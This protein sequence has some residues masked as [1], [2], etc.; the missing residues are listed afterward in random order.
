MTLL[1]ISAAAEEFPGRLALVQG[2]ARYTFAELATEVAELSPQLPAPR[3]GPFPLIASNE[4]ETVVKLLALIERRVPFLPLHPRLCDDERERLV[5]RALA[6]PFAAA[7]ADAPMALL[8]TS[9]TSAEPKGVLLPRSAFEIAARNSLA[10]LGPASGAWLLSMPLSHVGGLSVVTRAL[11]SRQPVVLQDRFDPAAL[12]L[13]IRDEGVRFVSVVPSMLQQLLEHVLAPH[14]AMAEAIIVG[15]APCPDAL[16]ARARAMGVRLCATYGLTESCAMATLQSPG[17]SHLNQGS[18]RPLDGCEFF[19]VD[20]RGAPLPRGK[21]GE[22][23]LDGPTLFTGYLGEPPR[24]G[25]HPTGDL[26]FLDAEGALHVT[27]RRS[28]LII[29]GGENVSPL[30]I[31]AALGDYPGIKE[32]LA[33]G[34]PDERWGERVALAVVADVSGDVPWSNEGLLLRAK[35]LLAPFERPR[36]LAKVDQLPLTAAGKPDRRGAA[37]RLAKLL[38]P[39]T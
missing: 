29:T 33:F 5:E 8:F 1:S 4:V 17:E 39:L 13:A 15:G 14:L 10:R 19:I 7:S 16:A 37:A 23:H 21:T 22:L 11:A 9:G 6:A 34:V 27:G 38:R 20:E 31:E 2:A 35:E 12:L 18:G 3:R 32:L 26:G 25:P 28:E 24:R 30:A 36:L